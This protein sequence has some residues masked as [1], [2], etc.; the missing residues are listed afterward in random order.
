MSQYIEIIE[1]LH[2]LADWVEKANNVHCYSVPRKAAYLLAALE[3]ENKIMKLKLNKR[4]R[5]LVDYYHLTVGYIRY[6]IYK[7][8]KKW[9]N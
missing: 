3:E 7:I 1:E 9:K 8:K 6:A 4:D 2:K 5:D